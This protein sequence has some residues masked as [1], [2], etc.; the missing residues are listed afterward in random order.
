V[1]LLNQTLALSEP[2]L[3]KAQA[4]LL[5]QHYEAL[6]EAGFSKTKYSQDYY[7]LCN[8]EASQ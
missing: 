7:F 6:V 1:K 5:R 3:I 8:Q 2:K 4:E